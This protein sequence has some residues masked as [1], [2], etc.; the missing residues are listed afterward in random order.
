MPKQLVFYLCCAG[1]SGTKVFRRGFLPPGGVAKPQECLAAFQG[2]DAP[3]GG[4][5][6]GGIL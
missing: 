3:H 6:T 1:V 2:F 5:K 4:K